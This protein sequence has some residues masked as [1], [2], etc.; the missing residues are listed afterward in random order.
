[1]SAA[2]TDPLAPLRDA[3]LFPVA[4][5]GGEAL[6]FAG[7]SLGLQP[8]AARDNVLAELDDW[9]RFGVEGHFAARNPW[10]PY[11]ELLTESVARLL[12]ARPAEVVV[13][14]TLTVNLHLMLA[15]FYRPSGKRCKIL[16]EDGAF[17]S[18]RYAAASQARWHG[19]DP[20]TTVV[21]L[22]PLPG[23]ATLRPEAILQAIGD[24][25]DELALVL[26]GHVNYLT[27]QAFDLHAITKAGHAVGATVGFDLAHG[28]GNLALQLHDSGAD[29]AVWCN[30]KYLNAGPGGLG[31]AFVHERHHGTDL[32][33]LEGWWGHDKATRF[34]MPL[35]FQPIHGAEAWQLSN[36]PILPLAI[37]RASLA[38]FDQAGMVA[39]RAKSERLTRRLETLL[40][41]IPPEKLQIL[42]PRDPQQRG[43]M[44]TV[45]IPAPLGGD[46][47]ARAR[48]VVA[49]LHAQ[50][51]FV[52]LRAP[53]IV[54]LAPAPLYTRFADVERL[55]DLLAE[56]LD[57]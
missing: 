19:L 44:L 26:L 33:R 48:P 40:D 37:L 43:A 17:P 23:E 8:R 49:R 57:A 6:Y 53:D 42:T 5:D 12:G 36:P 2:A 52:D 24:L 20:A 13:M 30:Y 55:G 47:A 11:H 46:P 7:H 3:F 54:R 1:M 15:S 25:G 18:D 14:N 51:V 27:G 9:A 16:I 32:P 31:G 22:A 21:A 4:P 39:L 28:A 34:Q 45:R 35:Q 29:F 38:L 56:A 41:R 10:L 50:G